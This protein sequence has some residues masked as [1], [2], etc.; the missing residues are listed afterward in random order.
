MRKNAV[1]MAVLM[2]ALVFALMPVAMPAGVQADEQGNCSNVTYVWVDVAFTGPE[3]GRDSHGV[4]KGYGV[5]RLYGTGEC[6]GGAGFSVLLATPSDPE[7]SAIS[8]ELIEHTDCV[9]RYSFSKSWHPTSPMQLSVIVVK[10]YPNRPDENTTYGPYDLVSLPPPYPVAVVLTPEQQWEWFESCVNRNPNCQMI[11]KED[12]S[13]KWEDDYLKKWDEDSVWDYEYTGCYGVDFSQDGEFGTICRHREVSCCPPDEIACMFLLGKYSLC[14]YDREPEACREY[15]SSILRNFCMGGGGAAPEQLSVS[16]SASPAELPADGKN[17]SIVTAI[18][19]NASGPVKGDTVTF[20]LSNT[21]LGTIN[22]P[23]NTTNDEG[24]TTAIFTAGTTA[25]TA[26]ITATE[27]Q[28]GASDTVDITLTPVKLVVEITSPPEGFVVHKGENV[29]IRARVTD[30]LGNI[31]NGSTIDSVMANVTVCNETVCKS[32]LY[33][34]YD[35]GVHEDGAKDDGV[36]ATTSWTPAEIEDCTI[37][38]TAKKTG[39]E[40][41][42]AKVTGQIIELKKPVLEIPASFKGSHPYKQYAL[43]SSY[44]EDAQ[45][46]QR[47]VEKPQFEI[48]C[49]T[50]LPSGYE[51]RV[52]IEEPKGRGRYAVVKNL[53]ISSGWEG[54]KV[55]REWDYS[56]D[57]GKRDKKNIP[58]GVYKAQAQLVNK[59]TQDIVQQSDTKEFYV[60]FDWDSTKKDFIT[61]DNAYVFYNYPF[62]ILRGYGGDGYKLHIYDERIWKEILT[63][64]S[65]SRLVSIRKADL[66][67]KESIARTL[68]DKNMITQLYL[69]SL[70]IADCDDWG[71]GKNNLWG[72]NIKALDAGTGSCTDLSALSIGFLRAVGIPARM[73][74]AVGKGGLYE[75]YKDLDHAFV[76]ARYNGNWHWFDPTNV[77][78]SAAG[79]VGSAEYTRTG[80]Q[81]RPAG[82]KNYKH[83]GYWAITSS[84]VPGNTPPVN[85]YKRY[86]YNL[87]VINITFDKPSGYKPGDTMNIYI[88]VYNDRYLDFPEP[89]YLEVMIQSEVPTITKLPKVKV[90]DKIMPYVTIRKTVTATAPSDKKTIVGYFSKRIELIPQYIVVRP[91][92]LYNDQRAYTTTSAYSKKIPEYSI[93]SVYSIDVDGTKKTFQRFNG[94]FFETNLSDEKAYIKDGYVWDNLPVNVELYSEV[95]LGRNYSKTIVTIENPD[96][97]SHVYNF[98]MPV[99]G[100]GD[101]AYVP[102]IGT[103]TSNTTLNVE[104]SHI[105]AYNQSSAEDNNV[106]IYE[107]SKAAKIK[108]IEIFEHEGIKLIKADA[109]WNITLTPG[110]SH[111]FTVYSSTRPEHYSTYRRRYM[112]QCETPHTRCCCTG[113]Y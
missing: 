56:T 34:L 87:D 100:F 90:A 102:A 2:V 38:V 19:T 13:K 1:L 111:E 112:R 33:E 16:V 7:G 32:T 76:E 96:S 49:L 71:P 31:V 88:D 46:F 65:N 59:T 35:D 22:P 107:L 44:F 54:D 43:P 92:T 37:T 47:G 61:N 97:E 72:D 75:G 99:Y 4:Y 69:V 67:S 113:R 14:M 29:V 101:A 18:V 93:S 106:S 3:T 73:V 39:Y 58:I 80:V 64:L 84:S 105:I 78:G 11:S 89:S 68:G 25:G 45:V 53:T 5:Y 52:M 55:M 66:T 81:F 70:A 21:S 41:G 8:K 12:Y 63:Q 50:G 15:I 57:S 20:T 40:D 104:A 77:Y 26:T 62:Y 10:G 94:T 110:S 83:N 27:S 108:A 74:H 24:R 6:A 30:D 28:V 48:K 36:Y 82:A 86:N 23:S 42:V 91:Y 60:I 51:L 103:I 79:S 95:N 98:S 109:C 9:R 85:I 17:Q